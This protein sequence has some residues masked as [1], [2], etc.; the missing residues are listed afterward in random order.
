M[1]F[2]K[3]SLYNETTTRQLDAVVGSGSGDPG[4]VMRSCRVSWVARWL[5]N[6][7]SSTLVLYRSSSLVWLSVRLPSCASEELCGM[8]MGV[9]H[10]DRMLKKDDRLLH[11][12]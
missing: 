6:E 1:K 2:N 5:G 3:S 9:T 11:L 10:T 7:C 12:H 4:P 8:V